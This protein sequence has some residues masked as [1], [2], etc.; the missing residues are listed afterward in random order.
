MCP[1]RRRVSLYGR[2]APHACGRTPRGGGDL[3]AAGLTGD[4]SPCRTAASRPR[5]ASIWKA[6]RLL[7]SGAHGCWGPVGCHSTL[8]GASARACPRLASVG[9][10]PARPRCRR[11]RPPARSRRPRRPGSRGRVG[12]LGRRGRNYK[13]PGR[14]PWCA[15]SR[16]P[17][18]RFAPRGRGQS[19][20]RCRERR[21]KSKTRHGRQARCPSHRRGEGQR[22][23]RR[24]RHL[25]FGYRVEEGRASLHRGPRRR[26]RLRQGHGLPRLSCFDRDSSEPSETPSSFD[27]PLDPVISAAAPARLHAGGGGLRAAVPVDGAR[28]RGVGRRVDRGRT[29]RSCAGRLAPSSR[30]AVGGS[31][32][33]TCPSR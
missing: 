24:A 18:V 11:R 30:S 16:S 23:L 29:P 10:C 5:A 6:L 26:D 15:G 9:A 32:S 21:P 7:R 4:P 13:P 2:D 31:A 22:P 3:P 19:F 12:E 25:R 28:P 27:T 20:G 8:L 14:A 33:P 1:A 17:G